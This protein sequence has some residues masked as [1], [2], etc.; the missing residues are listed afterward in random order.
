MVTDTEILNKAFNAFKDGLEGSGIYTV[1][2]EVKLKQVFL[3]KLEDMI[4]NHTVEDAEK[5]ICGTE[6]N[7]IY[8]DDIL[9]CVEEYVEDED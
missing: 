9:S 5:T 1:T 2:D 4:Y 6:I 8:G 3:S 7:E